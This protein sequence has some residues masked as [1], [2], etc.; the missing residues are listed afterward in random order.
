LD[1]GIVSVRE[2]RKKE[3]FNRVNK[4]GG[5]IFYKQIKNEK[6]SFIRGVCI[7]DCAAIDIRSLESSQSSKKVIAADDIE[8]YVEQYEARY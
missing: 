4:I 8:S 6:N 1:K 7:R 2:N 3:I 5:S